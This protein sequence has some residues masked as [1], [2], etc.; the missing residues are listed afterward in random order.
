MWEDAVVQRT[1]EVRIEIEKPAH[2]TED[3]RR[4][5][6]QM[7][8]YNPLRYRDEPVHHIKKEKKNIASNETLISQLIGILRLLFCI[9]VS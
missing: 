1:G 2:G 4:R 7:R 6:P 8:R 3:G 5:Y 9:H